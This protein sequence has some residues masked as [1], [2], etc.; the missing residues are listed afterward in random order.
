M[1]KYR[2][3]MCKAFDGTKEAV[4]L[5]GLFSDMGFEPVHPTVLFEDNN[6]CIAQ[7]ENPL[8]KDKTHWCGLSLYK[9]KGGGKYCSIK[10]DQYRGSGS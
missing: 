4:W 8:Q 6:S 5:R 3:R 10:K 7:T 2:L 1:K 9:G